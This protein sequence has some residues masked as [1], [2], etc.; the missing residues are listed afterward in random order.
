MEE[1]IL[2]TIKKLLGPS[3]DYDA[4]DTDIIL[5][6]NTAFTTLNEI[7]VG[8]SEGF[9]IEDDTAVWSSYIEDEKQ[10]NAVKTY[11]YLKVKLI[12]DP[13]LN[14]AVLESMKQTLKEYEWRLNIKAET[15]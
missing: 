12:F 3:G 1:S 11:I 5:H 2:K 4:F 7:G 9:M 8:P 15:K 6:I 13:P 14:S 10:F